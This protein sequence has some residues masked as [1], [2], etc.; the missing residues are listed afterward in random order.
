[1][2]IVVI[3]LLLANL[4]LFALTRLDS[5][6]GGEAQ[7]LAE[8]VQPEKVKLLTPQQVAALG[9]TKV[10]SLN[11]VCVE[12]GPLSEAER[13]RAMTELAPLG[14][15]PLVTPRRVEAGGYSVTLSGFPN[16]AA[17]ERRAAELRARGI[18]DLSVLDL[19]R[20]QYAVALGIFRTESAAN[21]RA[22]ALAQ[23]GITGTRVAARAA[24]VQQTMLV[25]RD[26]PQPAVA[27]L[28]ELAP[29][30]AGTEI[31]VGGCERSS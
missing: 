11:D 16:L 31:R 21:G 18:S 12:W 20:G 23:Q 19:G 4:A 3:L 10:A 15:G 8:Q 13:T 25:F 7:R 22:D 26:P 9:P 28:R 30:Y 5:A 2:R 29:A 1:M 24:G 17:A 6:A 14:L 27:K